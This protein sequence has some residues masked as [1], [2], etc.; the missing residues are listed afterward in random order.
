MKIITVNKKAFHDY[1]ILYKL[2]A[3]IVLSGDEVKSIREGN[4]SLSDSYATIHKGEMTLI[5]CHIAS[6]SHAYAKKEETRKSRKLLLHKKEIVKLIGEISR[7]GLTVLPLRVYLSGKG[8][9]KVE[10]GVAKHK[11]ARGK[12]KE[13]REKDIKREAQRELKER[14]R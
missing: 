11:L 9:V 7:K 10:I 13:L 14:V 3:G 1:E 2:E 4:I 8:L 12:K 5:N 6:Y